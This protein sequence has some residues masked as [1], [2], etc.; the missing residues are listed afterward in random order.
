MIGLG[1]Q[2]LCA[3]PGRRNMDSSYSLKDVI[4]TSA[5]KEVPDSMGKVY[6]DSAVLARYTTSTLADLISEQSAIFVK[7]YGMGLAMLSTDGTAA[8]H[9]KVYWNGISL[10]SPILGSFDLNLFPVFILDEAEIEPGI[11]SLKKGSG[12]FGGAVDLNS[13]TEKKKGFSLSLTQSAG[14]FGQYKSY[15]STSYGNELVWGSTAAYRSSGVNDYPF[16][17]TGRANNPLDTQRHADYLQYGL[18]QNIG[19]QLSAATQLNFSGWY[20]KTERNLP[21]LMV[22]FNETESQEDESLRFSA[23]LKHSRKKAD[24]EILSAYSH[25][26]LNYLNL[27]ASIDSRSRFDH[28]QEQLSYKLLQKGKLQ[29]DGGTSASFDNA[30]SPGYGRNWTQYHSGIFANLAYPLY[31][32]LQG[33]LT[34]RQEVIDGKIMPVA[35]M[36]KLNA[37]FW[38]AALNIF[39]QGGQNYSYPTLNDLYWVPG[40]NPN[41]KPEKDYNIEGGIAGKTTAVKSMLD[42]RGSLRAY[43][44]TIDDYILWLPSV[45]SSLWESQNLSKVWARGLEAVLNIG[46]KTAWGKIDLQGDYNYTRSTNLLPNGPNDNTVGRQLI[47]IPVH[48]FRSQ[49]KWAFKKDFNFEADYLFTGER[50]MPDDVLPPYSL[51][52]LVAGKQWNAPKLHSRLLLQVKCN[53]ILNESYQA[54]AWRAMPGR[55]YEISLSLKLK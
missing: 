19:I 22:T 14:S 35:A 41:L 6:F 12:G 53:N 39:A 21:P 5:K 34:I 45:N 26:N 3:Q 16:I 8:N 2:Q 25:E 29:L 4:I 20:E 37:S 43:S 30:Y 46:I 55:W 36:G 48:N 32:Q 27:L 44:N 15:I 52:N 40:G 33:N 51:L 47:Y 31:K 42:L 13:G 17:N 24:W 50:N 11:T 28:W 49:L 1:M 9:T 18:I 54:I 38:N 10:N 23:R 7:S